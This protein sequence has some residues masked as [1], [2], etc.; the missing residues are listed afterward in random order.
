MKRFTCNALT[1]SIALLAFGGLVGCTHNSNSGSSSSTGSTGT[2]P[3]DAYMN[4]TGNWQ[5]SAT[6]TTGTAPFTSLSGFINQ[7]AV[8]AVAQST[9][10]ALLV[11]STGCYA[12]TASIPLSGNVEQA[13]LSLTSFEVDGQVLTVHATS[14]LAGTSLTGTY[15]VAGGCADGA[16]GTLS[17]TFYNLLNGTYK[18]TLAS[19]STKSLTLSTGQYAQ[20]TGNGTFLVT[21]SATITGFSCFTTGTISAGSTNYVSGNSVVLSFPTNESSGSQLVLNGTFDVAASVITISS[22]QV[23]GGNCS[24]SYGNVMLSR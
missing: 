4:I 12:D 5:I 8:D 17:G 18:G 13:S 14:D 19:D 16:S 9:S 15:S 23:T 21:G 1:R 7:L 22:V 6:P 10:A 3:A 11:K 2:V 20:G 24:G